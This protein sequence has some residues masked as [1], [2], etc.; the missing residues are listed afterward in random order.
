[1]GFDASGEYLLTISH[2][3]RGVFSARTWERVA[4]DPALAYPEDGY[5]IGIGP[6][7]GLPVTVTEVDYDTGELTLISP[8]G[9][10]VLEYDSGTITV[11]GDRA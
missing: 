2:G 7:A 8:D 1:M 9:T 6:I 5:G 3:G 4:R 10:V 11:S